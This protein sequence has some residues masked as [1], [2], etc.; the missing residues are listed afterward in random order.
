MLNIRKRRLALDIK[1]GDLAKHIGVSQATIS[2]W[3]RGEKMPS[4][5]NLASLAEVLGV[6]TDYLL[7]R[8]EGDQTKLRQRFST[9]PDVAMTFHEMHQI[10]SEQGVALSTKNERDILHQIEELHED[11]TKPEVLMMSGA[12]NIAELDEETLQ[13]LKAALERAIVVL[14]TQAKKRFTPKK[15]RHARSTLRSK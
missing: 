5:T 14:T 8:G 13:L 11:L 6:S 15:Y 12:E 1:Q 10:A 4:A 3:E 2:S 7:G 9:N